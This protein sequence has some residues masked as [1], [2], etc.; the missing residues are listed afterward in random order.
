MIRRLDE[1]ASKLYWNRRLD[2]PEAEPRPRGALRP[3][4][5]SV[6][7]LNNVQD[8]MLMKRRSRLGGRARGWF[9]QVGV[10]PF[11]DT[12][13]VVPDFVDGAGGHAVAAVSVADP[14]DFPV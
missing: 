7:L 10:I 13:S 11:D 14:L 4:K 9:F 1:C 6:L 5:S 3:V 2:A 8:S 12:P